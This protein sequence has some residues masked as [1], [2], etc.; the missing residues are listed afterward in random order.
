[1]A[2]ISIG[3]RGSQV[4]RLQQQLEAAGFELGDID[5]IF[6]RRTQAAVQ[7]FQRANNLEVDGIVGPRTTE[8]LRNPGDTF[9]PSPPAGNDRVLSPSEIRG[10]NNTRV[11]TQMP[12]RGYGFQSYYA[13]N[14][15]WGTARTVETMR[16]AAARF[17]EA[18]G[19]TMRIGDISVRGGG[20]ISGH[21]AHRNGR[22]VDIDMQ[23]SDGRT[24]I[25]RNRDSVN[26][27]WRSPAYDRD[28]TRRMIQE[29]RRVNPNADILFNDPVLVREGLVRAF[30]NH[31]NHLHVQGL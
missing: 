1:M 28:A 18:T 31:D 11:D 4:T 27:T 29:I 6:G 16:T 30:P 10:L 15:R 25:E 12:D 14:K 17:H 5:G 9:T 13:A 24:D 23:F 8:R 21:N 7:A 2:N 3:A 19:L 26:A 22:N 20:P